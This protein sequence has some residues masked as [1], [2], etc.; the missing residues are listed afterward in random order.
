MK[1]SSY[2]D[3]KEKLYQLHLCHC[4]PSLSLIHTLHQSQLLRE[5]ES[6]TCENIPDPS[7]MSSFPPVPN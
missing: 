5:I 1:C 4:L 6:V 7:N 3:T 2:S